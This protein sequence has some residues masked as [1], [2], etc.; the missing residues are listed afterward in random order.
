MESQARAEASRDGTLVG[1]R[2]RGRRFCVQPTRV[3]G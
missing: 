3:P 2:F 1:D